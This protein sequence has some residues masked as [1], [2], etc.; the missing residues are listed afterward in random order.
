MDRPCLNAAFSFCI[1]VNGGREL[2]QVSPRGLAGIALRHFAGDLLPVG[3]RACRIS[4]FQPNDAA[5]DKRLGIARIDRERVRDI[6][7]RFSFLS[8]GVERARTQHIDVRTVGVERNHSRQIVE[9]T[10]PVSCRAAGARPVGQNVLVFRRQLKRG[11][12]GVFG[13]RGVVGE[14]PGVP[15]LIQKIGLGCHSR[16]NARSIVERLGP[17]AVPLE[18][19]QRER[20]AIK[21][22][23]TAATRR[24]LLG[25]GE[26]CRWIVLHGSKAMLVCFIVRERLLRSGYGGV[27]KCKHRKGGEQ[28]PILSSDRIP[29]HDPQ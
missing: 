23:S 29:G 22:S 16:G 2:L 8:F 25:F 6:G 10:A 3:A 11:A 19:H 26:G 28:G 12:Q 20:R 24:P 21:R 17:F 14:E 15:C 27:G 18:L 13:F 5:F 7:A 4:A 9:R 1:A